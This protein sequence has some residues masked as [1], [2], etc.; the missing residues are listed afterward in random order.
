MA[1][2]VGLPPK[3]YHPK[4]VHGHFKIEVE[5]CIALT[6]SRMGS[7]Q[8]FHITAETES[9]RSISRAGLR[10]FISEHG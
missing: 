10:T 4:I 1:T 5:Q 3:I 8:L 6:K 2:T 7:V 9:G